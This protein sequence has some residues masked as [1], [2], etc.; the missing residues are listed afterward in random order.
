MMGNNKEKTTEV[1]LLNVAI[2][3]AFAKAKEA[4][5]WLYEDGI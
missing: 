3:L 5:S 2:K 1:G 4:R